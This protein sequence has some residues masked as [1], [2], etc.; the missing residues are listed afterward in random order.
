[1]DKSN[2]VSW[3]MGFLPPC[4]EVWINLQACHQA[5][6][7][8]CEPCCNHSPSNYHCHDKARRMVSIWNHLRNIVNHSYWSTSAKPVDLNRSNRSADW[9]T[10]SNAEATPHRGDRVRTWLH[11]CPGCTRP[12]SLKEPIQVVL[13]GFLHP[14]VPYSFTLTSKNLLAKCPVNLLIASEVTC[15]IVDKVD[16]FQLSSRPWTASGFLK[17]LNCAAHS[18]I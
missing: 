18:V 12:P 11:L 2:P 16:A 5:R 14:Q 7:N 1:M 6:A 4:C 9:F 10:C 13:G 17:Y 3:T 15:A 8:W